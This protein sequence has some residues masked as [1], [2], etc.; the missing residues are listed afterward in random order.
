VQRG[1][2]NLLFGGEGLFVT[3][4]TGPGKI[5]VQTQPIADLALA[6]HALVPKE[7]HRD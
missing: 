7:S 1:I 3:H 6:L 5:I 2:K 4:V